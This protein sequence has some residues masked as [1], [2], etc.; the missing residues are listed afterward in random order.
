MTRVSGFKCDMCDKV[1]G[2]HD[3]DYLPCGWCTLVPHD[4]GLATSTLHFCSIE[5]L[6]R[7]SEVHVDDLKYF[8]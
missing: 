7:W 4:G 8:P 1:L 6:R 5:C 2:E 3:E